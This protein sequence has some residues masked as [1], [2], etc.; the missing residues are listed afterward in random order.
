MIV[1]YEMPFKFVG[2]KG[3]KKFMAIACPKIRIPSK[4]TVARDIFELFEK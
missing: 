3:F 2:K 1:I 4:I